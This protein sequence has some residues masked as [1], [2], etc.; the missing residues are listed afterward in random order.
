MMTVHT[1]PICPQQPLSSHAPQTRAEYP[2]TMALILPLSAGSSS[3]GQH[4]PLHGHL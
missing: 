4:L 3:L 2:P 1:S